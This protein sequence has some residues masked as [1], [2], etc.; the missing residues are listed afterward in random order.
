M[1]DFL[2]EKHLE[3]SPNPVNIEGTEQILFQ[4]KNCICKIINNDGI[5]GTGFFC[6]IP[7]NDKLLPFLITNNH[8]LDESKI[9]NNKILEFSINDGKKCKKVQ[10]DDSRIK[11]TNKKLD[12]TFIEIKP[13]LD[14]INYFLDIDENINSNL[15][16]IYNKESIY[17]LHYPKGGN[18]NV[19]YGLSNDIVNDDINHFC[20]TETGSSGAPI[21]L[22]NSYKVFAIHKGVSSR[23]ASQFNI[24]VL[25]KNAINNYKNNIIIKEDINNNKLI[26]NSFNH[27]NFN[28]NINNFY[29]NN[30]MNYNNYNDFNNNFNIGMNQEN[31]TL[32]RLTKEFMLCCK[33]EDLP[34]IVFGFEL[35]NNNI[36]RWKLNMWGPKNTPY[37]DGIF[38]LLVIF[39][40]DYPL[41]GPE[42]K[43]L[44][45]IIHLNVDQRLERDFGHI[46]LN[47]LNEWRVTGKVFKKKFYN[48]KCAL[49]DIFCLFFNQGFASPY[50]PN[51][52]NLYQNNPGEFN[53]IARIYTKKYAS[54]VQTK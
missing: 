26:N 19:S 49:F 32:T 28:N 22:L 14:G 17:L 29:S 24:G 13:K 5:K 44:N 30:N 41:H 12:F 40:L 39:P 3:K 45:K 50:D 8:V 53:R 31:Q 20:N 48:V 21:L 27:N 36:F 23:K 25:I 34:Q 42:F 52:A 6:R 54:N 43:F 47:Y 10:L 16:N 2:P 15:E 38:Q 1:E 9:E 7:I 18:V 35:E 46:S 33:D 37:E 4:M 11:Y 51:L